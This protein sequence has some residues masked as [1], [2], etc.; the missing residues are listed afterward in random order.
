MLLNQKV[1]LPQ[2]NGKQTIMGTEDIAPIIAALLEVD[3]PWMEYYG[4]D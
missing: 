1:E 3:F 2:M 4:Q